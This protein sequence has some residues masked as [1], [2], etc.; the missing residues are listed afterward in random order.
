MAEDMIPWAGGSLD[1]NTYTAHID[2]VDIKFNKVS[3]NRL[4]P[5][6]QNAGTVLTYQALAEATGDTESRIREQ[7]YKMLR[8]SMVPLEESES[9][10]WLRRV[11][12]VGLQLL[13]VPSFKYG[14][15][16]ANGGGLTIQLVAPGFPRRHRLEL[17]DYLVLAA[18][19]QRFEDPHLRQRYVTRSA[20][21]SAFTDVGS[22]LHA[23]RPR[24]QSA[25][26]VSFPEDH[27]RQKVM[28]DLKGA[29]SESFE[30]HFASAKEAGAG[31]DAALGIALLHD[32]L[33]VSQVAQIAGVDISLA[34]RFY[35]AA[36]RHL[37][38]DQSLP[39]MERWQ[40][41]ILES[42]RQGYVRPPHTRSP[43]RVSS[44]HAR[45][46]EAMAANP[47]LAAIAERLNVAELTAEDHRDELKHILGT[48]NPVTF[49]LQVVR[50]GMLEPQTPTSGVRVHRAVEVLPFGE[51]CSLIVEFDDES[52]MLQYRQ[53]DGSTTYTHA[54]GYLA[55]YFRAFASAQGTGQVGVELLYRHV[56]E[57]RTALAEL[58][59]GWHLQPIPRDNAPPLY[60]MFELQHFEAPEIKAD[61]FDVTIN[62]APMHASMEEYL[63][64]QTLFSASE[65]VT[66]ENM[67]TTIWA[68]PSAKRKV[69]L[70]NLQRR[71]TAQMNMHSSRYELRHG[72]DGFQLFDRVLGAYVR[73]A[74]EASR[75]VRTGFPTSALSHLAASG[76]RLEIARQTMNAGHPVELPPAVYMQYAVLAG[77]LPDVSVSTERAARQRI[78]IA[79]GALGFVTPGF[80]Q[81]ESMRSTLQRLHRRRR[82]S[83]LHDV[84]NSRDERPQVIS[85]LQGTRHRKLPSDQS[86]SPTPK[87]VFASPILPHLGGLSKRE[88]TVLAQVAKW[89]EKWLDTRREQLEQ[90][91]SIHGERP[92]LRSLQSILAGEDVDSV[93]HPVLRFVFQPLAHEL[94]KVPYGVDRFE[95]A[96]LVTNALL[97][98]HVGALRASA[99]LSGLNAPTPVDGPAKDFVAHALA[100]S[101]LEF[102]GW[103]AITST[104]LSSDATGGLTCN[105]T[106]TLKELSAKG[107]DV[108]KHLH[109]FDEDFITPIPRPQFEQFVDSLEVFDLDLVH[110]A[111]D[112]HLVMS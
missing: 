32:G 75:E 24:A 80:V 54:P 7:A 1:P 84:A 95:E 97:D 85:G 64:L 13:L 108:I 65:P 74:E 98:H 93:P 73:R 35:S 57:I 92:E 81:E 27:T 94:P 2:G 55:E 70:E 42:W 88:E 69:E 62:G 11:Y 77:L 29:T 40:S 110:D 50:R 59:G 31:A 10:W 39:P 112:I 100:T 78:A 68:V 33:L 18:A 90:M 71:I 106:P 37:H 46:L 15:I 5:L 34:S 47:H 67:L 53:P 44:R 76:D 109:R 72:D 99:R 60:R 26:T 52:L 41:T 104:F 36:V 103:W 43:E 28:E 66:S 58:N 45:F 21:Q 6:A 79:L 82:S 20:L 38:V 101:R 87:A 105:K 30:S 49:L 25:I 83:L 17:E 89:H 111:L 23:Y 61:C 56:L 91:I 8:A 107:R 51:P 102:G 3:F 4:L 16:R 63:F 96:W 14:D 19:A 22:S 12:N 48:E 9:P 86:A